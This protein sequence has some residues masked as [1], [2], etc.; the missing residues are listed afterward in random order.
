[1]STANATLALGPEEVERIREASQRDSIVAMQ[2]LT[3]RLMADTISSLSGPAGPQGPKG[4]PGSAGPTG[5]QGAT[6][7]TG[8]R[9][10]AG[11]AGAKGERG[12][13]GERGPAGE[14]GERGERGPAGPP[15]QTDH[16]FRHDILAHMMA[17]RA[18]LIEALPE[19]RRHSF[20]DATKRIEQEARR[21]LMEP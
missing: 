18:A 21:D 15:G 9:G 19:A 17:L 10:P 13:T 7:Q 20:R 16:S 4:D 6:G 3:A 11:E 5:A 1:M 2:A 14:R 8:D 12:H